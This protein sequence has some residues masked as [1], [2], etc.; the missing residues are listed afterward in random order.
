MAVRGCNKPEKNPTDPQ[1]LSNN[2]YINKGNS[3][4]RHP[5][6]IR[7][8]CEK[9]NCIAQDCPKPCG[10]IVNRT[11][12]GHASHHGSPVSETDKKTILVSDTDLEGN[13][14]PQKAVMYKKPHKTSNTPQHKKGTDKLNSDDKMRKEIIDHEDKS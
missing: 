4:I 10:P 14:K 1:S 6:F 12:I 2:P 11:A 9:P 8:I 5:E 13:N 3:T 7:D